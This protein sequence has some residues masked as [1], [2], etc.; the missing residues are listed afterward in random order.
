MIEAQ[1]LFNDFFISA[2]DPFIPHSFT[3]MVLC[4]II[5]AVCSYAMLPMMLFTDIFY[6]SYPELE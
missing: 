5:H 6:L 2:F 4:V 3:L 1:K